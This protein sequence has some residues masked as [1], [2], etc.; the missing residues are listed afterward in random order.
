V[1]S[2][3]SEQLAEALIEV[4]ADEAS[5]DIRKALLIDGFVRLTI[6]DYLP[7]LGLRSTS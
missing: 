6:D 2:D 3:D 4:L 7:V 1:P 5:A